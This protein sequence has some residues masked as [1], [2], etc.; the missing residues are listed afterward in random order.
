MQVYLNE[1]PVNRSS[2]LILHLNARPGTLRRRK[3]ILQIKYID[4]ATAV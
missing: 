4:V 3:R 1:I 2:S